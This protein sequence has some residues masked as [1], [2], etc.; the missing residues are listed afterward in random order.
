MNFICV[1]LVKEHNPRAQ[2]TVIG[3]RTNK[4]ELFK[5][6]LAMAQIVKPDVMEKLS[7]DIE[8]IIT[9]QTPNFDKISKSFKENIVTIIGEN[10]IKKLKKGIGGGFQY[11]EL[12]EPLFDEYG[13]L[14]EK[15]SHSTLAKHLYFTEF[16]QVLNIQIINENYLGTINATSLYLLSKEDFRKNSCH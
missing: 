5:K 13:L 8:N 11:C 7:T 12:S 10:N 16:G 4:T 2:N 15:I 9:E 3:Y 1:A 6:K 14:N